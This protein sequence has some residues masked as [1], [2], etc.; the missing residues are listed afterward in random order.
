MQNTNNEIVISTKLQEQI[1]AFGQ[2]P[3]NVKVDFLRAVSSNP[4][5]KL[6]KPE[7]LLLGIAKLRQIGVSID[8]LDGEGAL[9]PYKQKYKDASGIDREETV[10]QVQVQWKGIRTILLRDYKGIKDV[11]GFAY[12]QG[13]ATKFD[14]ITGQITLSEQFLSDDFEKHVERDAKATSGYVGVIF[15][16][17]E[18]YGQ[19]NFAIYMS[20]SDITSH[21]TKYSKTAKPNEEWYGNKT[22]VKAVARKFKHKL[23]AIKSSTIDEVLKFDQGVIQQAN[24]EQVAV[25]YIDNPNNA[26]ELKTYANDAIEI[27]GKK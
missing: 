15:V 2:A 8:N 5:L 4:A 23:Q 21:S 26:G 1:M 22:V 20:M 17:K 25:E 7:T 18:I 14:K 16:D 12:K 27:G 9:I 24:N 3:A 13:D 11:I 19:E 10:A 6:A